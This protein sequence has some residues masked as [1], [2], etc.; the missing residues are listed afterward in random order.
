MS[1]IESGTVQKEYTLNSKRGSD[2]IS[3][4]IENPTSSD[5]NAGELKIQ[6]ATDDDGIGF[7]LPSMK[8]VGEGVW[9]NRLPIRAGKGKTIELGA[10]RDGADETAHYDVEIDTYVDEIKQ[11]TH[12]LTIR[13]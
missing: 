7:D 5:I 6:I 10:Y 9:Q 3:L 4:R 11:Q 2:G 13:L 12:D 1:V 8:S